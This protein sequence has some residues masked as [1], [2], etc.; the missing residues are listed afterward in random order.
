MR[1]MTITQT[2]EKQFGAKVQLV[3]KSEDDESG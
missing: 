2:G 3:G 1:R